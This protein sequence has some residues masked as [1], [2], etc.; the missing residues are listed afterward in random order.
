M[1]YQINTGLQEL[2]EDGE[3]VMQFVFLVEKEELAA[4]YLIAA[5][6]DSCEQFMSLI[7]SLQRLPISYEQCLELMKRTRTKDSEKFVSIYDNACEWAIDCAMADTTRELTEA[8]DALEGKG[9]DK[10]G[11]Q[12]GGK[13]SKGKGK[14]VVQ[15]VEAMDNESVCLDSSMD[16]MD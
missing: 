12:E 13:G 11:K 4:R 5:P 15:A 7:N 1:P 2:Q 10:A 3:A 8:V 16:E 14:Q 6:D 9:K